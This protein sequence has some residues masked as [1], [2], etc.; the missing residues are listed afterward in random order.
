MECFGI[1]VAGTWHGL[2]SKRSDI[3]KKGAVIDPWQVIAPGIQSYAVANELR[4]FSDDLLGKS[5][6][7]TC[8]IAILEN[9]AI[10]IDNNDLI[11][12]LGKPRKPASL[13]KAF[14][15]S[16]VRATLKR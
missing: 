3:V 2:S 14:G 7:L 4:D 13:E 1:S 6:K 8:D 5:V 15:K 11:Q 10:D 9:Y 16:E 12:T